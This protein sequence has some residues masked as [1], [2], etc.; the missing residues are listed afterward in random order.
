MDLR[1][2]QQLTLTI[3]LVTGLLSVSFSS[4]AQT[5]LEISGAVKEGRKGLDGTTVTLLKNGGV[6]KTLTTTANGKFDFFFESNATYVISVSKPGYVAKKIEFNTTLPPEVSTTFDFEFIVELFQ[7]QSGL[8]KAIF[9]NPVAKVHYNK[10]YN[11]FD[12]DLDYTMEFQKQEEEVFEELERIKEEEYKEEEKKR[13]EAEQLAAQQAK[14]A[15]AARKAEE[16]A[17]KERLAEEERKRKEAEAEA[18]KVAATAKAKAE[19]EAKAREDEFKQLVKEAEQSMKDKSF[20]MAKAKLEEAQRILPDK[21][22]SAELAETDKAIAQVKAEAEE[23]VKKEKQ[24]NDFI[25]QAEDL[26]AKEKYEQAIK[27]YETAAGIN[28][29]SELPGQRIKEANEKIAAIAKAEE[30]KRKQEERYGQLLKDGEAAEAIKDY[31]KAKDMYV[32]A[33]SLKPNE[34]EPNNRIKRIDELLARLDKE[35]REA[36]EKQKKFDGYISKGDELVAS[37]ELEQA[38]VSYAAASMVFPDD[39]TAKAKLAEVDK[40]IAE[41]KKEEAEQKAKQDQFA[42]LLSEGGSLLTE[43][44]L[45]EAKSKFSAALALEVDNAAAQQRLDEVDAL[46]KEQEQL[47]AEKAAT[48]K[49]Y[50]GTISNADKLLGKEKFQDALTAYQEAAE[51]LPSENY[52]KQKISEIEKTLAEIAV[53]AKAE[54]EQNLAY[55]KALDE[56]EALFK[57][58]KFEAALAKFNGAA[59]IRPDDA[60]AEKRVK[61]TQTAIAQVKAEEEKRLAEEAEAKRLEEEAQ[62]AAEIEKQRQEAELAAKQEKFGELMRAGGS[63]QSEIKFEEAK[64]QYEQALA[65]DVDNVSAQ[66]KIDA[67]AKLIEQ[68]EQ[69]AAAAAEKIKEYNSLIEKADKQLSKTKYNEALAM[70]KQ[71]SE[72]VPDKEYPKGKIIEIEKQLAAL[73]E[74]QKLEEAYAALITSGDK[75]VAEEK[76]QEARSEFEKALELKPDQADA[77]KRLDDLFAEINRKAEEE[78][79]RLAKEEAERLAAEEKAK[80][81]EEKRLAAEAEAK[82]KEEEARLAEGKA[83]TGRGC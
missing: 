79:A 37:G 31:G 65:L 72:L 8:N 17:E 10:R 36:E 38:K 81:E 76:L 30:E 60:Q 4:S 32:E 63:L 45:A 66:A 5:G 27:L 20:E 23:R 78:K 9:A 46:V 74:E 68:Q 44:K 2:L 16:K 33:G 58:K 57:E 49:R 54:E 41:A 51:I 25:S 14:E 67:V 1:R 39:E 62:K 83:S 70:Y 21:D 42:K 11:E 24:F 50:D 29:N 53:K 64:Y 22:L 69:E 35:R 55:Q 73:E 40:L 12:Y 56:A 82:R 59:E 13:K 28:P 26:V 77:Q 80:L 43:R 19:A 18:A 71:A 75:L 3:L 7:D 48:Q 6:E 52:P 34:S 47:A 61:E 15:E